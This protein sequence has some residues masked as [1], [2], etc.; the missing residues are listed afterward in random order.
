[1]TLEEVIGKVM[2]RQARD[3]GRQNPLADYCIAELEARGLWEVRGGSRGESVIRGLAREKTWDVVFKHPILPGLS[4][5]ERLLKE[6]PRLLIS[7]KS[8]MS[9]PLGTLP[10]RLDDL[11][12]EVS[13]VQMLYPEVVIGYVV[14]LDRGA[15]TKR[16]SGLVYPQGDAL[17]EPYRRFREGIA[18]LAV[19]RPPLWA[20]GLIEAGWVIEIDTRNDQLLVDQPQ[21]LLEGKMFFDTLVDTLRVREPALFTPPP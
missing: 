11:V 18:R 21:S 19:R 12:G 3:A 2:Q 20:Q 17:S 4:R 9:N 10:N 15:P 13:S 6:K 5:E 7:L 14:L 1:M 8:I 16:K